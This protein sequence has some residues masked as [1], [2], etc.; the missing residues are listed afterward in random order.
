MVRT[1]LE[2]HELSSQK[3]D[4]HVISKY[5][6]CY[7]Q[8]TSFDLLVIVNFKLVSKLTFRILRFPS[9][10]VRLLEFKEKPIKWKYVDT[11]IDLSSITQFLSIVKPLSIVSLPTRRI[12]QIKY[13]KMMHF[14]KG[15]LKGLIDVD[16]LYSNA[17]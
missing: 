10:T 14:K 1:F 17:E 13:L 7:L 11:L 15:A 12:N 8:F 3:F 2:W 4:Y 5:F 9:L 16:K 6:E